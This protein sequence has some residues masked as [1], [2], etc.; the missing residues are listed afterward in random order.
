MNTRQRTG[1]LWLVLVGGLLAACQSVSG[2]VPPSEMTLSALNATTTPLV[3]AVNGIA[4]KD[5]QPGDQVEISADALPALPW[6]A[7]VRLP[8]GR[9]LL[10]LTV[11]FGDVDR[12]QVS[13]KGDA[14]RVDLSCGRVDLWSGPPLLGPAPLPGTPGDCDP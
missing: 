2:V 5:L 8:T 3:L 1:W 13:L 6:A 11:R 4:V 14:A 9:P 12:G 7:E 10:S